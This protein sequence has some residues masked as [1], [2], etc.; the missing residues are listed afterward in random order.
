LQ[1]AS[2]IYV[3]L[4]KFDLSKTEERQ[5]N[6]NVAAIELHPDWSRTSQSYDADIAI[7]TLAEGIQFSTSVKAACLPVHDNSRALDHPPGNGTVV[8]W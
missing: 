8:S 1:K 4:G 7:L 6:I 5:Q 2:S 3:Q